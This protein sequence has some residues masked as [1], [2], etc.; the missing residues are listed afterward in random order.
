MAGLEKTRI[1]FLCTGNSCRSQMAEGW[2]KKLLAERFEAY[3]AGTE[4]RP[5]DPMAIQVMADAGVDISTHKS[6]DVSRFKDV[7]LD[8]VV[9][10]CDRNRENC[11]YFP[12]KAK[13]L[14][15]GFPD[16]PRLAAT[17]KSRFLVV[18]HYR[19]VRDQIKEFV[20]KLPALLKEVDY[21]I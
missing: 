7:Q 14:H 18:R 12:G 13:M 19:K 11:P 8:Y 3:S 6:K 15:C 1:L 16:P 20:E 2:A 4:P 21:D 9:T 5:V 10:I 17:A